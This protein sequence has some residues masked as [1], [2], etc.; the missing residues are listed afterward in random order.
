MTS[1]AWSGNI[2]ES[3]LACA[4]HLFCPFTW[5]IVLILSYILSVQEPGFGGKALGLQVTTFSN[6][7]V[8]VKH[9]NEYS[10]YSTVLEAPAT[11]VTWTIRENKDS[12]TNSIWKSPLW[13]DEAWLSSSL[14]CLVVDP[15]PFL[16]PLYPSEKANE[17]CDNNTMPYFGGLVTVKF[18][19]KGSTC[20]DS[21]NTHPLTLWRKYISSLH[22]IH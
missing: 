16:F 12:I 19:V 4:T 5:N 22:F 9:I 8:G 18:Y 15:W 7:R 3:F 14:A 13:P 6:I 10:T 2:T 17:I 20:K 11:R 21:L 1:Q